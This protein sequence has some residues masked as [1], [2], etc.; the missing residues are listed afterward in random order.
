MPSHYHEQRE[1]FDS[2]IDKPKETR[3]KSTAMLN[4]LKKMSCGACGSQN[5]SI[6][7]KQNDGVRIVGNRIAIK[8]SICESVT[9]LIL[10]SEFKIDWAK[11]EGLGTICHLNGDK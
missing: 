10:R 8:C 7:S 6:Y 5:F 11:C 3:K 4:G 9:V 1:K 2:E